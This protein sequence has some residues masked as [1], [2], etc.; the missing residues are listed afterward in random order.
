[1]LELFIIEFRV[2]NPKLLLINIVLTVTTASKIRLCLRGLCE[3]SGSLLNRILI[4]GTYHFGVF[5]AL[6]N[7]CIGFLDSVSARSMLF[8]HLRST[9]SGLHLQLL[10]MSGLGRLSLLLLWGLSGLGRVALKLLLE[11]IALVLLAPSAVDELVLRL[12]FAFRG[13]LLQSWDLAFQMLLELAGLVMEL[14]YALWYLLLQS[15]DLLFELG[16]LVME[17]L[18]ALCCLLLQLLDLVTERLFALFE[19]VLQVCPGCFFL[20]KRLLEMLDEFHL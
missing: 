13:L 6:L 11:P 17:L 19:S 9:L 1:M 12:S 5:E 10:R 15:C 18:F 16:G 8:F 7:T 14:S 20:R 2:Q 4:R 3:S